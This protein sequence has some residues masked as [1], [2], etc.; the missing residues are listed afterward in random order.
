MGSNTYSYFLKHSSRMKKFVRRYLESILNTEFFFSVS[1][2][3]GFLGGPTDASPAGSPTGSGPVQAPSLPA[4]IRLE[5]TK[6]QAASATRGAGVGSAALKRGNRP[7]PGLN[8]AEVQMRDPVIGR[9][10]LRPDHQRDGCDL[11]GR[12]SPGV[13]F[14]L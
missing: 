1:P 13:S 2:K 8:P 10:P 14:L 3:Y 5:K 9:L 4:S 11:P 7:W 6:F 12:G